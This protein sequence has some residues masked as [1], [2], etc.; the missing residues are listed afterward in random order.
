MTLSEHLGNFFKEFKSYVVDPDSSTKI[1]L[2]ILPIIGIYLLSLILPKFKFISK[3]KNTAFKVYKSYFISSLLVSTILFCLAIYA[4]VINFKGYFEE[5]YRFV[6]LLSLFVTFLFA[7][8]K[9]MELGELYK[10]NNLKNITIQPIT[11]IGENQKYLSLKKDFEKFKLWLFLPAIG[12]LLLFLFH[13]KH[14]LVSIVIDA[15]GSMSEILATGKKGLIETFSEV[16]YKTT[17][18]IISVT[19]KQGG[20]DKCNYTTFSSILEVTDP[21][22]ICIEGPKVFHDESPND[23]ID[24]VTVYKG[25]S[26][27]ILHSIWQ[28]YLRS[29]QIAEDTTYD[30]KI[31]L[32]ASDFIE[33]YDE[34]FKAESYYLPSF[35]DSSI[36][37][38]KY[39]FSDFYNENAF[40][41]NLDDKRG[42]FV[43]KFE[44]CYPNSIY[45]G[46]DAE[47]YISAIKE[48]FTDI[49]PKTWYFIMWLATFYIIFSL[50]IIIINPKKLNEI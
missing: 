45:D 44:E 43:T 48:I 12:F 36:C 5:S 17:D 30:E 14:T 11:H 4:W 26:G 20:D 40:L 34:S 41:I 13:K 31:M 38:E 46:Y 7:I 1:Y 49:K 37:D 18:F 28:N 21:N 22:K 42:T 6:F 35:F 39:G 16:D 9:Y 50:I 23:F 2:I 29:K 10:R 19:P 8:I 47:I 27:Y 15:S 32:V 3:N 33:V 25:S 24:N